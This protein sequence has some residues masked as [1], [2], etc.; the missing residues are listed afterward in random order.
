MAD[1]TYSPGRNPVP[2]L[3]CTLE[4][5]Q[6]RNDLLNNPHPALGSTHLPGGNHAV[7]GK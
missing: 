1:H 3:R 2:L 6:K 5:V 4:P 7:E